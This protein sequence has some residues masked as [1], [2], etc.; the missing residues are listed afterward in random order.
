VDNYVEPGETLF[1]AV[2]LEVYVVA[3]FKE[4]QLTNMHPDQ[5]AIV[6]VNAYPD[7]QLRGHVDSFQRAA[8]ERTSLSYH[9]KMPLE[10]S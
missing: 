3:N 5:P 8:P 4:T 2:P 7:I 10:T 6:C 9:R 1:S